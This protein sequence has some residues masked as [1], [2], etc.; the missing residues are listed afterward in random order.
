MALTTEQ[1]SAWRSLVLLT[2]VLDSA[3]D[4]Q[5]QRDGGLPHAYY[6]VI[7]FLYETPGRRMTLSQ[8]ALQQRYS[9]SRMTHAVTSMEASGWLRRVQASHDRRVRFVELTDAGVALV[10][11][12]TPRQVHD[13]RAKVFSHLDSAQVE[14]LQQ[15]ALAIVEG[16]DATPAGPPGPPSDPAGTPPDL[17]STPPDLP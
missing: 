8:L 2:H 11:A 1:N 7:V 15:I 12:I 6:K 9:T 5:A 10:R 14:Q 3:L 13:V 4:A 17:P 16:L